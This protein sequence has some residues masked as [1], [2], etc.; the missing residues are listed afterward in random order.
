[1]FIRT[2]SVLGLFQNQRVLLSCVISDIIFLY[3]CL[4]FH[5]IIILERFGISS[6][7]F[8]KKEE[9]KVKRTTRANLLCFVF[10]AFCI[11]KELRVIVLEE[12]NQFTIFVMIA[13]SLHRHH[14]RR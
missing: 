5:I 4:H 13:N 11:L 7:L 10:I 14:H 3:H 8:F 12:K 2:I 6:F 9:V 1:M